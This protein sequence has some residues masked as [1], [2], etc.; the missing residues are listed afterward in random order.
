MRAR[1]TEKPTEADSDGPLPL[2]GLTGQQEVVLLAATGMSP[3]V[4]TETVWGLAREDPHVVPNRVVVVTT[5]PGRRLLEA[6]LLTPPGPGGETLWQQLRHRLLGNHS[7]SGRFLN[8]ELVREI[9]RP[10]PRT[11]LAE[12]LA[13]F[14]TSEENALLADFLLEQVRGFA[15]NPGLKLIASIAGGRKTLGALLYAAMSLLGRETDRLTHVLVGEPFDHPGLKPRFY[16]PSQPTQTLLCADGRVVFARDAGIDLMD[17][18]FVPLRNLFTKDTLASPASFTELVVRCRKRVKEAAAREVRLTIWRSR[19]EVQVNEIKIQTSSPQQVL[20]LLLADTATCAGISKFELAVEPMVR[21]ASKLREDRPR[22]RNSDWR[23][24]E[25]LPSGF[26]E[27]G[28]RR[29]LSELRG[30]LRKAGPESLGLLRALPSRGRFSLDLP[31]TGIT[32][33]D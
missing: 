2:S 20:L 13:D 9:C 17:I 23:M 19:R 5:A 7:E 25:L 12:P 24:A 18:P 6:E 11:G 16:Y 1:L 15:E 32:V 4:L 30:K 28:L 3:A 33:C 22:G 26:D 21:L 10:N 8:L 27:Q 29:T 14:R 31:P